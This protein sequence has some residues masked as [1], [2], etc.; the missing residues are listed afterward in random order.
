MILYDFR[1]E[2]HGIFERLAPSGAKVAECT[3]C[4]KLGQRV[5]TAP[6]FRLDGTDPAFPTAWDKWGRDHERSAAKSN[7]KIAEHGSE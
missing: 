6:K 4:G 7:A 2:E 5:V 1:C 3:E